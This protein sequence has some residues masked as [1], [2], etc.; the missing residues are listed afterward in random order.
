MA[1]E[2]LGG[3]PM[4]RD[5]RV[6]FSAAALIVFAGPL[7]SHEPLFMMSH[8]A[9][10]KGAFDVHAG[11]HQEKQG[12]G[13]EREIQIVASAE[14]AKDVPMALALKEAKPAPM[15]VGFPLKT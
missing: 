14:K 10:G 1:S 2:T 7:W 8:E 15:V 4:K 12:D 13:T 11:F 5:L 9:P 3:R 6:L